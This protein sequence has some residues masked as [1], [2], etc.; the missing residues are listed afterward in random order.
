MIK[1]IDIVEKIEHKRQ[2]QEVWKDIALGTA[3]TAATM[4]GGGDVKAQ[5]TPL[6]QK[7]SIERTINSE[8]SIRKF[9]TSSKW[10][11]E[12]EDGKLFY[13]FF[14]DGTL[15]IQGGGG[16]ETMGEGKWILK[17]DKLTLIDDNFRQGAKETETF[18]VKI[19][20]N[21]LVLGDQVFKNIVI[22]QK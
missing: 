21:K 16:E 22:P 18:T 8:S 6:P 20:G 15:F 9:L 17:G 11:F 12:R 13:S 5:T 10:G 3:L 1:L 7:P 19:V 4:L 2:L 14:K